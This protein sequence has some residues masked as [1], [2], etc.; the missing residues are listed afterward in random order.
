M[1]LT[2]SGTIKDLCRL[3]GT[4]DEALNE[5]EPAEYEIKASDGEPLR[6][7]LEVTQDEPLLYVTD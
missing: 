1:N 3:L 5:G 7:R 4:L 6:L 2:I